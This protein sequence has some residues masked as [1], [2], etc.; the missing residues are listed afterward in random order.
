M[1]PKSATEP[2]DALL[3]ISAPKT[4]ILSLSLNKSYT[5]IVAN[6]HFELQ[7]SN[8]DH[9]RISTNHKRARVRQALLLSLINTMK[10]YEDL[11]KLTSF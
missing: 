4:Q 10:V 7:F 1:L 3:D 5:G 9:V 6:F 11:D 2:K 8:I